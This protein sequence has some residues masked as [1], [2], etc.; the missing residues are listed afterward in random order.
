MQVIMAVIEVYLPGDVFDNVPDI[1]LSKGLRVLELE[2]QAVEF[3]LVIVV[4]LC[5]VIDLFVVNVTLVFDE[6]RLDLGESKM[7]LYL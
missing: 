6:M 1:V 3:E 2:A 5:F 4:K 7:Q